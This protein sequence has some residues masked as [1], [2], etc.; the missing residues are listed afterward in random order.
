MNRFSLFNLL[1]FLSFF[2]GGQNK[3]LNADLSL[4]YEVRRASSSSKKSPVV[5]LLH[6][7]GGNETT[8]YQIRDSIPPEY[9]V[10][11]AQAPYHV[12]ASHYQWFDGEII[13][14]QL[15]PDQKQ[16][17][18]T[19]ALV[20]RFI[21]EIVAKY[22]ADADRVYLVGFS[23]G[24]RMCYEVGLTAPEKVKGIGVLS[25][26]MFESLKNLIKPSPELKKLRVFIGHGADDDWIKPANAQ[27]AFDYLRSKGLKPELHLYPGLQHQTGKEE[28]RDLLL[29]LNGDSH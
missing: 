27:A 19:R 12:S 20:T 2:A 18:S 22:K 16:L 4:K 6:G 10:I 5:I 15:V 21:G 14:G 25:G 23:Q 17:D 7:R 24:A 3:V 26:M 13:D 9:I 8:M 11:V 28:I 29:W 1:L